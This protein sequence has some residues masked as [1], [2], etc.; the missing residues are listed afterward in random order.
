MKARSVF[1]CVGGAYSAQEVTAVFT[2]EA[3]AER[4]AERFDWQVYK[5]PLISDAAVFDGLPTAPALPYV[6]TITLAD[7]VDVSPVPRGFYDAGYD[8][9]EPPKPLPMKRGV[10]GYAQDASDGDVDEWSPTAWEETKIGGPDNVVSYVRYLWAFDRAAAELELAG[11]LA[12]IEA[13]LPRQ[14]QKDG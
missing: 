11:K 2:E 7:Y 14:P 6:L 3:E 5:R 8:P 10:H 12:E 13:S 4:W 1:V 9:R